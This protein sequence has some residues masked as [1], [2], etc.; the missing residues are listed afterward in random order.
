MYLL[1]TLISHAFL[2]FIWRPSS[3]AMR[4]DGLILCGPRN[5]G[6]LITLSA[7]FMESDRDVRNIG[8]QLHD[9]IA[10]KAME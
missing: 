3:D 5:P 6:K 8:E 10:S 1:L 9:I 7:M 4:G 2:S